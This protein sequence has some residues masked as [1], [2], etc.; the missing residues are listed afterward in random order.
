MQQTVFI[1]GASSGIGK[2]TALLF[3]QRG[4]Q[5]AATMRNSV[6]ETELTREGNIRLYRLDVTKP[7]EVKE[8]VEKSI[9]EMGGIGVMVN[10]AG[11]GLAGPVETAS[12]EKIYRQFN[13]NLFGTIRTMQAVLPHMRE[14]KQGVIIN[15]T[16]IGGLITLPYNAIYHATKFGLDGLSESMNYELAEFGIRVKTV[17]PGGVETDF[18]SRSLEMTTN[19]N[20]A[21]PYDATLQKVWSAFMERTRVQSAPRQIAEV[22]YTAATDGTDQL[23]YLAGEDAKQMYQAWKG[24]SNEDF[25]KMI[26]NNFGL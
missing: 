24:M 12:E 15:I 21:S 6:Q 2:A 7:E 16:S 11:Y 19:K 20:E 3:A 26:K 18:A 5:V 1:T 10:N 4:W 8:T 25:L 22:I 17:A 13:T 23:R 9:R 14:N